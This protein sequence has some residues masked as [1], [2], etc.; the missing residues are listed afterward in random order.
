MDISN[1]DDLNRYVIE[2]E[3]PVP[4][5]NMIYIGDGLTDV[6]CMRL[7]KLNGGFSIAVYKDEVTDTA[8]A[9]LNDDRVNYVTEADYNVGSEL[10]FVVSSVISKMALADM[11]IRETREQKKALKD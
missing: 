7:V 3:R 6:P 9:L 5:R 4:F 11:L 10:D 1:D 8:K 2:D